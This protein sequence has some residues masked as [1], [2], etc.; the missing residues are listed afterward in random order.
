MDYWR[1]TLPSA[2]YDV[3]YE[4]LV[5]DQEGESRNLLEYC[6]LDWE[7]D[8]LSFQKTERVVRT[9]SLYQVRRKIY[10]S[11]V[12]GWKKFEK[13][14]EPFIRILDQAGYLAD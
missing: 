10:S 5:A 12:Q 4:A 3:S 6:G 1:E 8:V 2:I 11:S 14:F 7:T 9:A 13:E